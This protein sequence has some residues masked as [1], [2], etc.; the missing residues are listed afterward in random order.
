[1]SSFANAVGVNSTALDAFRIQTLDFK[2][3]CDVIPICTC[4]GDLTLDCDPLAKFNIPDEFIDFGMR[5][6][7]DDTCGAESATFDL[8][9]KIFGKD[10]QEITSVLKDTVIQARDADVGEPTHISTVEIPIKKIFYIKPAFNMD[11]VHIIDEG[12]STAGVDFSLEFDLCI[13]VKPTSMGIFTDLLSKVGWKDKAEFCGDEISEL[14]DLVTD[15]VGEALFKTACNKLFR[16]ISSGVID[17][18]NKVSKGTK[19]TVNKVKKGTKDT[20]NKV[21]KG[22]DKVFRRDLIKGNKHEEFC[23]AFEELRR[24]ARL[25]PSVKN[26]W[27]MKI[28]ETSTPVT[29]LTEAYNLKKAE[30]AALQ[31]LLALGGGRQHHDWSCCRR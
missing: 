27:P 10:I 21:K 25:V 9:A 24:D 23:N 28:I 2:D 29:C 8:D 11:L 31:Q 5:V 4:A 18:I 3:I 7:L 1:M 30:E 20:V 6:D 19:D 13:G 12:N 16:D 22:L 26:F 17:G 14:V 15:I